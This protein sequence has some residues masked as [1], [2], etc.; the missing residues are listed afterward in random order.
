MTA[1]ITCR[2]RAHRRHIDDQLLID[3]REISHLAI[4]RLDER[5]VADKFRR[6]GLRSCWSAGGRVPWKDGGTVAG[7]QIT[8]ALEFETF[9]FA[10]R[11]F[12]AGEPAVHE[13]QEISTEAAGIG[14]TLKNLLR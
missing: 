11:R 12:F 14:M 9:Q 10:A 2:R 6:R 4:G 5:N 1:N 13:R 3:R 8:D 7:E